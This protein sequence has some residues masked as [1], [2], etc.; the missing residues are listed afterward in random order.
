VGRVRI[1]PLTCPGVEGRSADGPSPL[2]EYER[3]VERNVQQSRVD[4]SD[5]SNKE[6]AKLRKRYMKEGVAMAQR[7]LAQTLGLD[8][9][10]ASVEIVLSIDSVLKTDGCLASCFLDAGC[11]HIV[12]RVKGGEVAKALEACDVT[13][14]PRERLILQWKSGER[15]FPES[16]Q[17][18]MAAIEERVG[19]LSIQHTT[20]V[21]SEKL[22]WEELKT[23]KQSSKGK[24]LRCIVQLSFAGDVSI[25]DLSATV[26]SISKVFDEDTGAISLV[27]P[28]A[29]QLGMSYAACL[30]T[31]RADGFYPTIVVTRSNEALGLVYSSKESIIAALECGRGVYWSRSRGGLWRK[32]DTSG[33][34][35]TLHKIDADCDGDALR[36]MVT[37]HGEDRKA[38]CHLDTLS[39]WG[40]PNG[41]RH[42]EQTLARRLVD[43]PAG[44]YTKRLFDDDE[45]LRDKLVEEAQ[46]LSEAESRQHVAEELADVLYFA[47]VKATKA[48]VSIDDAVVELDK[49]SK[50]VTRRK[51]DSKAFRIEAGK[52]ILGG[53]KS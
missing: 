34:H 50:K 16:V 47:M 12:V 15:L 23:W 10:V 14:V 27:D 7:Y 1:H 36:F 31:D 39:C 52:Q 25:D 49:R 22:E 3:I 4:D 2:V 30:K 26:Q 28:T 18:Q 44:S 24:D 9:S 48:G 13:R 8:V 6:N 11:S 21:A 35:Q 53:K 46:E 37:Q 41:I 33:R 40:E 43:A 29:T 38:F 45:L 32:G 19:T 51:G 20:P 5:K 17:S 42:L